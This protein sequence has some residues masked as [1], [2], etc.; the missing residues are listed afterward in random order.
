LELD[1]DG[2]H[3]RTAP[4]EAVDAKQEGETMKKVQAAPAG[5]SG[6]AAAKASRTRVSEPLT[7]FES[8]RSDAPMMLSG[9]ETARMWEIQQLAERDPKAY[10]EACRAKAR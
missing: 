4:T 2:H 8:S 10:M 7:F 9:A 3:P 1:Y 5:V 6:K